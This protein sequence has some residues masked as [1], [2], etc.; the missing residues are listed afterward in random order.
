[1]SR[2]DSIVVCG[3]AI[4]SDSSGMPRILKP[5]QSTDNALAETLGKDASQWTR[6]D[7]ITAALS[8]SFYCCFW[9]VGGTAVVDAACDLRPEDYETVFVKKFLECEP[10]LPADGGDRFVPLCLIA[11]E[12]LSEPDG[13]SDSVIAGGW[14]LLNF[15][16]TFNP[17]NSQAFWDV[18]VLDIM[19]KTLDGYSALERVIRG[20]LIPT[21]LFICMRTIT[22][23]VLQL[24]VDPVPAM[25]EAGVIDSAISILLAF[26]T[27]D[28]PENASVC[29]VSF[30]ALMT[31]EELLTT[32]L[33]GTIVTKLR[34]DDQY[35]AALRY[36]LDNNLVRLFFPG[37]VCPES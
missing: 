25:Q 3:S 30:G 15:I 8:C 11:L 21:A 34:G 26:Q 7:A 27:L 29:V 18:G 28:A 5:Y 24:G 17:E 33:A 19:Q 32:G 14:M 13:Q 4:R 20:K 2:L 36:A 16:A 35:H 37:D 12:M 10:Y 31:L 1:M 9:E 23:G 22:E 6:D